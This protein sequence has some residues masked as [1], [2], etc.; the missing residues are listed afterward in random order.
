MTDEELFRFINTSIPGGNV[1]GSLAHS[2]Q[3]DVFLKIKEG[4]TY[5]QAMVYML[6][7]VYTSRNPV[8][9][10]SF[11]EF[12]AARLSSPTLKSLL[13]EF[14]DRFGSELLDYAKNLCYQT[15][16]RKK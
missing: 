5:Q 6:L 11:D 14:N 1:E 3:Q 12:C 10:C 9:S 4:A 8:K 2:F 15:Y 16:F 13:V 7:R